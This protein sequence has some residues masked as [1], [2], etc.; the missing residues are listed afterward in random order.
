GVLAVALVSVPQVVADLIKTDGY[1]LLRERLFEA[2]QLRHAG[3]N[4]GPPNYLEFPYDW[5][6]DLRAA[7]HRLHRVVAERLARLR[8]DSGNQGAKVLFICHSMG[9]LVARYHL[10]VL[11]GWETCRALITLGTPHRGAVTALNFLARGYQALGVDMTAVLRSCTSVY[12]LL[13]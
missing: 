11:G 10:E 12:Q 13:P 6:R 1:D 5:R 2:F 7:A 3:T 4:D 8:E 9:G